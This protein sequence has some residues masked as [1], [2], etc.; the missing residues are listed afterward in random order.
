MLATDFDWSGL[1]AE[2]TY[3]DT[4]WIAIIHTG[5]NTIANEP[6]LVRQSDGWCFVRRYGKFEPAESVPGFVKY[7]RKPQTTP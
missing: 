4:D 2:V 3:Q 7:E 5:A 6:V 1:K